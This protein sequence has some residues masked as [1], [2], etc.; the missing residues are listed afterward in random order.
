MQFSDAYFIFSLAL[1][2]QR[3]N[4]E[5]SR[6]RGITN[7][8]RF[9]SWNSAAVVTILSIIYKSELSNQSSKYGLARLDNMIFRLVCHASI[10][11]I[12]SQVRQLSS[13]SFNSKINKSSEGT[14][15]A[16]QANSYS[17]N[18]VS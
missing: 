1:L 5:A 2:G 18:Q 8:P 17:T 3:K 11:L 7:L 10:I 16:L 9:T 12:K 4:N 15:H 6:F 13:R 14:G